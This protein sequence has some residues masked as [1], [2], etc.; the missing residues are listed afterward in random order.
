[1][2]HFKQSF[3]CC[4]GVLCRFGEKRLVFEALFSALI[5]SFH[6]LLPTG[7]SCEK[8]LWTLMKGHSTLH[9]FQ[10]DMLATQISHA[11]LA[12]IFVKQNCVSHSSW[13]SMFLSSCWYGSL[14]R[15]WL[16]AISRH[17]LLVKV[18]SSA[19]VWLTTNWKIIT[20]CKK[21]VGNMNLI[22]YRWKQVCWVIL[23]RATSCSWPF[24]WRVGDRCSRV[25]LVYLHFTV[26]LQYCYNFMLQR[27]FFF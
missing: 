3:C 21:G 22:G 11:Q 14:L 24:E 10:T 20:L 5:F 23:W 15:P 25:K 19:T 8:L 18:D 9:H 1:M 6:R 26:F 12:F 13:K 17:N 16:L 27:A 4:I 7:K 2:C